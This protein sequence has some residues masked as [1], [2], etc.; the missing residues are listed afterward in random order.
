MGVTRFTKRLRRA[1]LFAAFGSTR[2]YLHAT[3]V[4]FKHFCNLIGGYTLHQWHLISTYLYKLLCKTAMLTV[5]VYDSCLLTAK[6]INI[7]LHFTSI[8]RSN[9]LQSSTQ[10]TCRLQRHRKKFVTLPL[11]SY[12]SFQEPSRTQL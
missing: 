6:N 12:V 3:H 2:G 4:V 10:R 7:C 11:S 8:S 1:C 5:L 9:R